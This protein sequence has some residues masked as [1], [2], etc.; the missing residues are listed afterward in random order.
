MARSQVTTP[1]DMQVA[2]RF[3]DEQRAMAHAL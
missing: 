1:D 3:L 2:E